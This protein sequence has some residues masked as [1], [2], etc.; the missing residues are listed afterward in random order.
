VPFPRIDITDG[1]SRDRFREAQ[2]A[3]AGHFD[4][5]KVKKLAVCRDVLEYTES[6]PRRDLLYSHARGGQ[7]RDEDLKRLPDAELAFLAGIRPSPDLDDPERHDER[8]KLQGN[9]A[10][11]VNVLTWR[12]TFRSVVA[13]IGIA[14]F[15][16][17]LV[18]KLV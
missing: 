15:A 4:S 5:D 1:V 11:A 8:S 2:E 18:A 17:A 3:A 6:D 14:A 7:I 13:G 16:V 10:R 9:I 12:I